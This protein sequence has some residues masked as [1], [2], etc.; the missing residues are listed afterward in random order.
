M[1]RQPLLDVLHIYEPLLEEG[2]SKTCFTQFVKTKSDCFERSCK[3]GH[4]TGSAFLLSFDRK[5]IL[6]TY[7]R[8]L[9]MWIQLGGHCD[10]ESLVHEVALRE[11]IEESGISELHLLSPIPFDIDIHLIPANSKE[12]AHYHFDVRY[13]IIA[14]TKDFICSDESIELKWVPLDKVSHYSQEPSLLRAIKKIYNCVLR[15]R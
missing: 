13:I 5:E 6:L 11:A 7:H 4:V 9:K 8:K 3:E 14:T 15:P 10:G 1:H 12:E 2:T